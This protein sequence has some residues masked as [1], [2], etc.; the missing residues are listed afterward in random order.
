M[1]ELLTLLKL[2]TD[3]EIVTRVNALAQ[4]ATSHDKEIQALRRIIDAQDS[5]INTVFI[6]LFSLTVFNTG[7]LIVLA[8]RQERRLDAMEKAQFKMEVQRE[9]SQKVA[10]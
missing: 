6:I 1:S 4:V 2:A 8:W 3:G 10:L 5:Y 9:A 7:L